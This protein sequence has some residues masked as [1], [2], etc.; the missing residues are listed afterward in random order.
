MYERSSR[1]THCRRYLPITY[2]SAYLHTVPWSAQHT[3]RSVSKCICAAAL[4]F[5]STEAILTRY[6]CSNRNTDRLSAATSPAEVETEKSD[7]R[8]EKSPAREFEE[9][10]GRKGKAEEEGRM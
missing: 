2:Q 6:S 5:C 8:T 10:D 1:P 3:S 9:E 4:L 7:G